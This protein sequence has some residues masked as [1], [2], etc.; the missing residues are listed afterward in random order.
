MRGKCLTYA[1]ISA[2]TP[3]RKQVADDG[4][5]I[6]VLDGN[7]VHAYVN[8]D[9]EPIYGFKRFGNNDITQICIWLV[10]VFDVHIVSEYFLRNYIE[11]DDEI[12]DY[13]LHKYR[14]PLIDLIIEEDEMLKSAPPKSIVYDL[15]R[16]NGEFID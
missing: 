5:L 16:D 8:S 11:S 7:C 14:S 3:I 4:H 10:R 9:Y 6:L 15:L 2:K 13:E 12:T 1:E